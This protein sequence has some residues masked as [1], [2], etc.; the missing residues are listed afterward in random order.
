VS[1]VFADASGDVQESNV[2]Y[3][4]PLQPGMSQS[5]GVED[6]S[7]TWHTAPDAGDAQTGPD[8]PV[9]P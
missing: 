7:A 5:V 3:T 4:D 8:H 1:V 2:A 9:A 6:G